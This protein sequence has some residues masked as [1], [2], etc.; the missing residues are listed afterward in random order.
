M[1]MWMEKVQHQTNWNWNWNWN[2]A[3]TKLSTELAA[4]VATIT[5]LILSQKKYVKIRYSVYKSKSFGPHWWYCFPLYDMKHFLHRRVWVPRVILCKINKQSKPK[6]TSFATFLNGC[7]FLLKGDLVGSCCLL[8]H[9]VA[10]V[11]IAHAHFMLKW[12]SY[13]NSYHNNCMV[14]MVSIDR[15][16][17]NN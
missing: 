5:T 11:G 13:G 17:T 12:Y 7:F 9:P 14:E 2:W 1:W 6:S 3:S 15:S 16:E 10:I 4:A 8:L